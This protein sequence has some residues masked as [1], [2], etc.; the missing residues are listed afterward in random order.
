MSYFAPYIDGTGYHYPTYNDILDS[1][2]TDMQTIYGTG[3]YLG[4]DSQDYELLSK[5]AEYIYDAYQAGELAYNS[6]S[7]VT[8]I[9]SGLDYVVAINGIARKQATRS[10]VQLTLS[11]VGGVTI[12]NGFVSDVNGVIWDL[13]E[14]V[15]I[16][17]SGTVTV[18]AI[19]R[20]YGVITAEPNTITK[21]M[22]P[23]SGWV[24]VTNGSTPTTGTVLETDSELRA[25]QANSVALPSQ[26]LLTGLVG[27][28]SGIDDVA[29]CAVYENDTNTTDAN[30][31][32][33]HSV[34]AVVEGGADIGCGTWGSTT[35]YVADD[36]GTPHAVKFSRLTTVDI[37]VEI[38]IT[39]RAGYSSSIPAAIKG[40]IVS[41]LDSFSIGTDLTASIIWMVAQ[42][43]NRDIRSP[44]FSIT[45]VKIARSG[46]TLSTNDVV[47]AYNEAANG[48]DTLITINVT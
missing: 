29:R 5:F 9:G 18:T 7:P 23:T 31:I 30:G 34:C 35:V 6:H 17:Q 13:P 48:R 41:Y 8:A 24:S 3:I 44:D 33:G 45:G 15:T 37:E 12:A 4:S 40:L 39:R 19:C 21:I 42:Q 26:S 38:D 2:I 36:F 20:E 16:E 25:R 11:G 14:S 46:G 28:L 32:P 22:T 1:L 10:T 27:A 43:A 47:I